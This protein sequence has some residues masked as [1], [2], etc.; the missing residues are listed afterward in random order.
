MN[1]VATIT[2]QLEVVPTGSESPKAVYYNMT[3]EFKV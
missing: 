1:S 3:M 2:Y